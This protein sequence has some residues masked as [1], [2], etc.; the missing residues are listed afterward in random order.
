M[1]E[2]FPKVWRQQTTDSGHSENT[3]WSNNN[4]SIAMSV[5]F[6]LQKTKDNEKILIKCQRGN[7][8]PY[9]QKNKDKSYIGLVFRN[10]VSI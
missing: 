3:M 5:M 7:Y 8:A 10:H 1:A 9:L 6:K 2:T 4:Q